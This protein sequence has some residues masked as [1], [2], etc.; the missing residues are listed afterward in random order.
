M[1]RMM[2]SFLIV[3]ACCSRLPGLT[4]STARSGR[5]SPLGDAR[6]LRSA[7]RSR[8]LHVQGDPPHHRP[9][10]SR[11]GWRRRRRLE[12]LHR[13]R[14]HRQ[15]PGDRRALGQDHGADSARQRSEPDDA[16]QGRPLRLHADARRE[17]GRDRRARSADAGQ[18][19]PD[20]RGTARRLHV[21]GR[22]A[23]LR[24]RAVR[25][26]DRASSIRRRRRCCTRSRPAT[27]CG[28]SSRRATARSSTPRSRI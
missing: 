26:R 5:T 25:Q 1:R 17:R 22:L 13:Q 21:R 20:E 9:I 11:T 23:H 3:P 4:A 12:D 7:R 18:E 15:L 14:S 10:P 2:R 24:R 6:R 16:D 8:R 27:A 19:D 28:R